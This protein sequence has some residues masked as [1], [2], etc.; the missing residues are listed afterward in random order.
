MTG[1]N[2]AT[3]FL[4]QYA[5][6]LGVT[7]SGDVEAWAGWFS[8]VFAAGMAISAPIWGVLADR[9]GHRI[10]L[11]RAL[12]GDAVTVGAL[13][14][15]R[16]PSQVLALRFMNGLVSGSV[17]AAYA[18]ISMVTPFAE[19]ASALG[20][21]QT[22]I[23]VGSSVG[24]TLGGVLADTSGFRLTYVVSGLFLA[25]AGAVAWFGT[26]HH[27]HAH[28]SVQQASLLAG[29]RTVMTS[30]A[31]A[32]LFVIRALITAGFRGVTTYMP[33]FVQSLS[34]PD[35]RVTTLTGVA[36]TVNMMT[37]ALGS[38][39]SGRMARRWSLRGLLTATAAGAA[40][41]FLC[42]AR[43]SDLRSLLWIQ[44]VSGLLMGALTTASVAA[45][46][47]AAPRDQVGAVFGL[48]STVQ[49]IAN[50]AGPLA[51]AALAVAFGLRSVFVLAAMLTAISA[52]FSWF[53]RSRT[54]A[55]ES[56]EG[57]R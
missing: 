29:V 55:P 41:T 1:F 5:Q 37:T 28:G 19:R 43:V 15:A 12:L 54:V 2:A 11:L 49:S 8:A 35:S 47:V 4:A 30:R 52:A 18:M 22:S 36:F 7:A 45:L 56:S 40:L 44:A 34:G 33:L 39:G 14:L 9:V 13:A 23:F 38:I 26:R 25:I 21:L 32:L 31:L 3:P 10:I 51:A 17:P 42:L 46:S 57:N 24:P 6:V 27:S 50:I 48:E 53:G 16:T 20:L